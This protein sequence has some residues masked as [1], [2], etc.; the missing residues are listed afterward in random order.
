MEIR[1][2]YSACP[3]KLAVLS[4]IMIGH[5]KL[6]TGNWCARCFFFFQWPIIANPSCRNLPCMLIAKKTLT[7][8][9]SPHFLSGSLHPRWKV[10]KVANLQQLYYLNL[11]PV[12]W[13]TSPHEISGDMSARLGQYQPWC[14]KFDCNIFLQRRSTDSTSRGKHWVNDILLRIPLVSGT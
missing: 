10:D 6:A 14:L 2:L 3:W 9:S 7:A 4:M 12:G 11:Q 5:W 13:S 8:G 1:Q